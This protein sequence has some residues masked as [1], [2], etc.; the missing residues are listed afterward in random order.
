[1]INKDITG[2]KNNNRVPIQQVV[3]AAPIVIDEKDADLI[4]LNAKK[5]ITTKGGKI[6]Y[7]KYASLIPGVGGGGDGE[8]GDGDD[9]GGGPDKPVRPD[10]PDLT[11]IESITYEQYYDTV[12]RGAKVKAILKIRNSSVRGTEVVGVDARIYNPSA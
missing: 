8:G 6:N 3:D 12:T 11:D 10:V 4:F 5:V 7:D 2:K 1:M 9:D